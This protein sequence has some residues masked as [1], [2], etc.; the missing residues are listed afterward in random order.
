MKMVTPAPMIKGR[1]QNGP[2]CLDGYQCQCSKCDCCGWFAVWKIRHVREWRYDQ[3]L[4]DM[5]QRSETWKQFRFQEVFCKVFAMRLFLLVL[6]QLFLAAGA[7]VSNERCWIGVRGYLE[8]SRDCY[9]ITVSSEKKANQPACEPSIQ[10]FITFNHHQVSF[11]SVP[12]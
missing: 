7:L 1:K 12:S 10:L 2:P 6:W 4:S 8:T 9:L 5:I 11:S 3:I